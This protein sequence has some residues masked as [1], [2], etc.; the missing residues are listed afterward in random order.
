MLETKELEGI[1][2]HTFD[3]YCQILEK[4][5]IPQF[6]KRYLHEITHQE[7]E[8]YFNKRN[9][10]DSNGK[11]PSHDLLK[12]ERGLLRQ[13]YKMGRIRRHASHDPTLGIKIPRSKPPKKRVLN[14]EEVEALLSACKDSYTKQVTAL[15]NT[16]GR[17]GGKVTEG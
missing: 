5:L 1:T 17:K 6:K 4:R 11:T 10:P 14:E 12:R 16:G 15:R 7:V 13:L 9:R 3:Q 2:A 8:S